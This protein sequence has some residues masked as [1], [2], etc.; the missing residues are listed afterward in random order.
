VS[1]SCMRLCV[2][3]SVL[4][5]ASCGEPRDVP[6]RRFEATDPLAIPGLREIAYDAYLY[7]AFSSD[8]LVAAS[9]AA[10]CN[11][12]YWARRYLVAL[13]QEGLLA[14]VHERAKTREAQIEAL[15]GLIQ[16]RQL[17]DDH[18]ESYLRQLPEKVAVQRHCSCTR[19][20]ENVDG[21]QVS[22]LL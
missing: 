21:A 6:Q 1:E 20:H 3:G 19:S 13:E 15:R 14:E 18:L 8:V 22:R 5:L 2:L 4:L 16:L 7:L 10:Y 12:A 11:Q 17:P 9:G